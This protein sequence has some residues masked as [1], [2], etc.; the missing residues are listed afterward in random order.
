M[1]DGV[2]RIQMEKPGKDGFQ[3]QLELYFHMPLQK[4]ILCRDIYNCLFKEKDNF[5]NTTF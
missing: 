4:H 5:K 1:Q 2:S 3:K